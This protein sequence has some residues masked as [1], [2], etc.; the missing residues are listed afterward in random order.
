M[1]FVHLTDT[2]LNAPGRN[3][4]FPNAN[5][6][7]KV[8]QTFR[9]IRETGVN[10]EFVL[11]TGDLVHEGD[12]EDYSFVRSLFDEA[13]EQLKV[14]V[15]VLL[16]NHDHLP[17]FRQGYLGELPAEEPYYYVQDINGLRL[18]C[19][20]SQIPG[21]P[22]GQI[23]E[24]QLT[25]L[26]NQLQ[27]PAPKGT[28]IA[29]HHP[30]FDLGGSAAKGMLVDNRDQ[31]AHV[32][33]GKDVIGIFAGHIH[34]NYSGTYQGI[35]HA[36]AAGTAFSAEVEEGMEH[37]QFLDTCGYNIIT[38]SEKGIAVKAVELPRSR[39]EYMR[40]SVASFTPKA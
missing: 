35:F 12:A 28:I 21:Q 38:I 39:A 29:L 10:P 2:H 3:N 24:V 17:A 33:S 15:Y 19:L 30:L 34:S 27:T 40:I 37:Y 23:D 36:A 13:S 32:I 11:I 5:H 18:I 31:V 6:F 14:P 20:N 8:K 22:G 4:Q 16:G 9:H 26:E 1:K 25:W 7:E